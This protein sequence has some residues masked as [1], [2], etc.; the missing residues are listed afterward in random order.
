MK[1]F[2]FFVLF[3]LC[4][5]FSFCS[6]FPEDFK[7]GSN[8]QMTLYNEELENFSIS[9][10]DD[11]IAYE[12]D[13]FIWMMDTS[14]KNKT[15]LF[16]GKNPQFSPDDKMIIYQNDENIFIYDL[17]RGQN[18][19]LIEGGIL[20]KFSPNNNN[21][22]IYL[23]TKSFPYNI[24]AYD[25]LKKV[26]VQV[27]D[28]GNDKRII[29][30]YFIHGKDQVVYI[31]QSSY[32]HRRGQKL[33]FQEVF[34]TDLNGIITYELFRGSD[35]G[36][37]Y[38]SHCGKKVGFVDSSLNIYIFDLE[39]PQKGKTFITKSDEFIFEDED[40]FTIPE[41]YKEISY[42]STKKWVPR[43]KFFPDGKEII[44]SHWNKKKKQFY[45]SKYFLTGVKISDVVKHSYPIHNFILGKDK[46]IYSVSRGLNINSPKA[47]FCMNF[48]K[49]L[50][51]DKKVDFKFPPVRVGRETFISAEDISKKLNFDLVYNKMR[52]TL[53]ISSERLKKGIEYHINIPQA[54]VNNEI[55]DLAGPPFTMFDKVIY[56]PASSLFYTFSLDVIFDEKEETIYI[57]Y[58]QT[59]RE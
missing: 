18:T 44:V 8:F 46:I 50:V 26:N 54:I 34:L 9:N 33:F 39:E 30:F 10:K 56:I 35:G 27:T 40:E 55:I 22:I 43:L 28:I 31:T 42:K 45:L 6:V 5:S 48:I 47:I 58:P 4:C 57:K 2:F 11:K 21:L 17:R 53:K 20:P 29:D 3:F 51:N 32:S 14:G 7:L 49:V 1:T 16:E 52:N 23:S 12:F 25:I 59:N 37:I 41:I 19:K 13:N 36:V 38:P 15:K 24:F